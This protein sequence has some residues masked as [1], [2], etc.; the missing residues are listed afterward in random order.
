MSYILVGEIK[1]N[2]GRLVGSLLKFLD[3]CGVGVGVGVEASS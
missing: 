2:V 1:A 3:A